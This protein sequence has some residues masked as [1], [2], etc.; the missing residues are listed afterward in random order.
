M[1]LRHARAAVVGDEE[2][3]DGLEGARGDEHGAHGGA[4]DALEIA[5]E[6]A[7]GEVGVLAAFADD[8]EVAARLEFFERLDE[9]AVALRGGDVGDARRGELLARVVEDGFAFEPRDAALRLLRV[10]SA[11]R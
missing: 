4:D 11:L 2:S 6:M 8:H 5:A 10:S 1:A 3:L 7:L 9:R